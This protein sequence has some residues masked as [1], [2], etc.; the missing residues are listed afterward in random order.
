MTL[1]E[2]VIRNHRCRSTHHYPAFDALSFI[3]RPEGEAWKSLFLVHHEHLLKGA[4]APDA[5]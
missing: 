4:R 2:R 1:P 5:A 3:A